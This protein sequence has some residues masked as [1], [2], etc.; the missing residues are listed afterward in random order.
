M[1]FRATLRIAQGWNAIRNLKPDARNLR[2]FATWGALLLS[3]KSYGVIQGNDIIHTYVNMQNI[4][5]YN[6]HW[7]LKIWNMLYSSTPDAIYF[8]ER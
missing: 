1:Y 7:F 3:Q 8:F 6:K 5:K 2:C 4:K